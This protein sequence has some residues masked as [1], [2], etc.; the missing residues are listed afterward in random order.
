M[1]Y[2]VNIERT[3]CVDVEADSNEEAMKIAEELSE[4]KIGWTE[5]W[6][7]TYCEAEE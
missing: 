4:D 6:E 5:D 2:T 3:G 7:E 1:K